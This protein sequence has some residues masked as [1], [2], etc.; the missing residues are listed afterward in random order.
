M[1]RLWPVFPLHGFNSGPQ[2]QA[3]QT[4]GS[5]RTRW[6][7]FWF[8]ACNLLVSQMLNS[9][10]LWAKGITWGMKQRSSIS[11][12]W[13]LCSGFYKCV[14][15]VPR[16]PV[17]LCRLCGELMLPRRQQHLQLPLSSLAT[18]HEGLSILVCCLHSL[19]PC[20]NNWVS[21]LFSTCLS[22][23]LSNQLK[24]PLIGPSIYLFI[25]QPFLM[26]PSSHSSNSPSPFHPVFVSF[27]QTV[28]YK[29][30]RNLQH[31][32]LSL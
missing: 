7:S 20:W 31:I 2:I 17:C 24:R 11:H 6:G 27:F 5:I 18:F 9:W 3:V 1:S 4:G 13:V 28:G 12:F 23:L 16:G 14:C 19:H 25:I 26:H 21:L 29:Q 30:Q 15:L 32:Y 10:T 22:A 8:W